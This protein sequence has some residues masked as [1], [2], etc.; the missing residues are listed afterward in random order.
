MPSVNVNF[1]INVDV[2]QLI[3]QVAGF[4]P[5]SY[6]DR[7]PPEGGRFISVQER[8]QVIA[9]YFHPTRNH[10]ATAVTGFR[11]DRRARSEA[12][13]GRWAIATIGHDILGG[14]QTFYDVQ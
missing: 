13:P 6:N 12:P 7:R 9:A 8:G 1:D 5:S 4:G 11:H 10:S 2:N 14:D 3:R